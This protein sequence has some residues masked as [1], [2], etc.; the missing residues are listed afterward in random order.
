MS[1]TFKDAVEQVSALPDATQEQIGRELL[2]H[3][4]QLQRLRSRL[5]HATQSLDRGG[6]REVEMADVIRRARSRYG[7]A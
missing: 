2:A 1:N 6:G 4:E 7:R 5:E 3:V